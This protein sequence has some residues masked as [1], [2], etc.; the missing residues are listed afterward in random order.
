MT[1][2]EL[3]SIHRVELADGRTIACTNPQ[4]SQIWAGML[5]DSPY[6]A[7]LASLRAG[8]LVLDVGAHIGLTAL[9]FS[10]QVPG[11]RILAFEPT[12]DT[13]ACLA[14]NAER[15][16]TG[17]VPV[18]AALGD[19][20]GTAELTFYPNHTM[21]A[22][23]VADPDDETRNMSAI[24]DAFGVPAGDAREEFWQDFRAGAR[25]YPVRVTTLAEVLDAEGDREVGLLK[26]DVERHEL[27]V[28]RG[29][30]PEQWNRV[31]QVV[32]EVHA[33]DDNLDAVVNLL[34]GHGYT[35]DV[36]QETVFAGGSVHVVYATRA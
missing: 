34:Q 33:I 23:L 21:M 14:D 20:P 36:F 11:L 15:L 26:I 17:V 7:G 13:Y 12:P 5:A 29:L 28:L 19:E 18:N 24:L 27:A 25:R 1:T 8:D 9:Y 10:E 31:R 22:T 6:D 30:R 16:M 2:D 4:D 32:A 3:L 35:T